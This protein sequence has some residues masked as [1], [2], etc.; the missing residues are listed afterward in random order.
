M[1]WPVTGTAGGGGEPP[2]GGRPEG[3]RRARDGMGAGGDAGGRARGDAGGRAR[4]AHRDAPPGSFA[5][6]VHWIHHHHPRHGC[7]VF[8]QPFSSVKCRLSG[9]GQSW[10]G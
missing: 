8:T 3:A 1:T 2:P 9:H 7:Y 6:L 4:G 5:R 10:E